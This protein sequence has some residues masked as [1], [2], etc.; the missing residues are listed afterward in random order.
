MGKRKDMN[1]TKQN[2]INHTLEAHN[3]A[4]ASIDLGTN[5]CRLLIARVNIASLNATYFRSRPRQNA[6]KIVDSLS[7]IVRLGEGLHDGNL[8][9]EDAMNRAIEALKL[10]KEKII[11]H[12]VLKIR[13]VATEACRR[14]HNK[15][16]LIRRAKE[17]AGIDIEIISSTEEAQLAITGCAGVL[18]SKIPYA[19]AFDIGGGSTELAWLSINKEHSKKPGYPVSFNI[20][21][22]ISLPYGVV[23]VSE[24]YGNHASNPKV[25]EELSAK[26]EADLEVFF[27]CHDIDFYVK[28]GDVQLIG[29]SG[30]VTTFAAMVLNL[31]RYDRSSIDGA[32][33][34]IVDLERVSN[35]I[36]N[37]TE[38]EKH[39][40][41]CIGTSAT[42]L[43]IVGSAILRGIYKRANVEKMRIADRGVRE[44]LLVNLL[45]EI[46]KP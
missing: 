42:D 12:N 22:S 7:R 17:E 37:M 33:I 1:A 18:D 6:W 43:I 28:K 24:A 39:D 3:P 15:D 20:M 44:G 46:L 19:L 36:L 45:K 38:K 32:T 27:Q 26:I 23:T 31:S 41:P 21:G 10:C 5:S 30:T 9:S 25:C 29:T 14:A 13:A 34:D 16:V 8:L 40:H 2:A 4:I 35:E 11:H